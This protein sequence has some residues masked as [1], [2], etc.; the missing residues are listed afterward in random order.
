VCGRGGCEPWS[1]LSI[2]PCLLLMRVVDCHEGSE[3]VRANVAGDYQEIAWRY[4]RQEPVLIAEGNNSHA[5]RRRQCRIVG[6][7]SAST[8][9]LL[10]TVAAYR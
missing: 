10:P 4:L 9:T 8:R 1:N 6:Q 5:D 3:P 7:G 2:E